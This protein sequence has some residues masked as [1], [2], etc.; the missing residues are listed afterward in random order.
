MPFKS[1][2]S[3]RQLEPSKFDDFK[4]VHEDVA[5]DGI[6]FIY[7]SKSDG[8]PEIQSVRADAELWNLEKFRA[9]LVEHDL[10]D[11]L[12]EPAAS[13]VAAEEMAKGDESSTPAKAEEKIKGSEKNEEGSASGE[14]GGI[15]VSEETETALRKKVQEHNESAKGDLTKRTD[16]GA[17]KAVYRRGAGAFSTSHRPGMTRAQWAY[18][19][20]NAFFH[21]LKTGKPKNAKYTS[22]NDLLPAGHPRATKKETEDSR[23]LGRMIRL[24]AFVREALKRGLQLHEAGRSGE[25]LQGATVRAATIGAQ[26]GEWSED[27]I[28]K[29]AAWFER[30]E[31]DRKLKGGRRWNNKGSETAGFVAW[32]L[33]GSDANDRGRQ[34]IKKKSKELKEERKEMSQTDQNPEELQQA[35][36]ESELSFEPRPGDPLVEYRDPDSSLAPMVNR[37]D[38]ESEE[39]KDLHV[40]RLGTLYDLDSGE[41]VM[42]MTEESARE[43][44]RTTSRMIE[45][46]HAIPI[47][48]EHGIEGGQR[49]QDGADR[50]PYGTV[51][52]VYYDEARRGIYA[53]KQWTKLGKSL[54]LDSMTEDGRTAVRVSPRVIMK[55]AYHPSTG[56]RLGE[57]YMD[58]VSLTTLPRQDR[59]ESV[60]LS[61]ST[62]R[63]GAELALDKTETAEVTAKNERVK[64]TE[65]TEEIQVLLARGS[66]EATAIYKAAGLEDTA[67]VVEL[68][69]KFESLTVELNRVNEELKNYQN[70]ELSRLAAEKTAEVESFLDAHEVSEVEREFFKVSLLSDDTKTAELARST[71]IS[72]GE[73]D[74]LATVEEALTEAKKRGAVP[75]DFIV[76]GELAELSRTAPS[77]AAGIINA[78]P[79][80]NTV[81]V[82]EPAGSNVAGVETETTLNKEQAGV[83]LSRIARNLVSEGKANSLIQAHRMAKTERPDLVAATKEN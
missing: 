16:L 46:G 59:M 64:M 49:G 65:K 58:V 63:I 6:D 50:R 23:E 40:L 7:G 73:P 47:S 25:G 31:S 38:I 2:H 62:I 71:I 24:P 33:W 80:E 60:A 36:N 27:K 29:A 41:M 20:V 66:D 69:R 78:I 51:L 74:K 67:P 28:I 4:R 22:D 8:L 5:P 44:A 61:R 10:T 45:A 54:L 17:V 12:I 18:A 34:W 57:S 48:F 32:L 21:L 15:E 9:W 1:E 14:R 13:E 68:A 70:E 53:R 77:V 72:R 26:S 75:A 39:N 37:E 83:E 43:I 56:D 42:N 19:R 82:G 81:R 55:P 79:G 76:D 35:A 3:A 30:H 11:E 52:G